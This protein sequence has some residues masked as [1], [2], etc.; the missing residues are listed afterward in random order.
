M[1][2]GSQ[3]SRAETMS[4]LTGLTHEIFVGKVV[5]NVRVE[6][7]ASQ[8]FQDAQPGDYK[9]VGKKMHF[10]LDLRKRN[11]AMATP[12]GQIPDHRGMDATKGELTP[13]R[14]YARLAMDNM[15][16]LRASGEG[17]FEDFSVRIF[18]QLWSA[19]ASMEIRHSIGSA[20]GLLCK[21]AARTSST[22]IVVKDLY[23]NAGT[24]PLNLL[25]EGDTIG[26]WDVSTAAVGGAAKVTDTGL[27][28]TTL[29][30]TVDSATTWETAVGNAIAADDLIYF[31]TTNDTTKDYFALE[32]GA[33]PNGMGDILDYAAA[34]TT[35][36]GVSETTF[37]R[38]KPFRQTSITFDHLEVTAHWLKLGAKRGFEV[39]PSTDAVLAFPSLVAQLARTLMSYQ[40]QANM[41]GTLQGGWSGL[42]IGGIDFIKDQY[43]PHN[44]LATMC[45]DQL[46][47]I[48]LGADAD[49]W[50]GDGSQWARIADFDG[51]ETYVVDYLNCFSP[52]RGAHGAL[53][54]I[55]TP[56]EVDADY[57]STPNY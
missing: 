37:P 26:W 36:F 15:V 11:G 1:A 47:R 43:L 38:W 57:D 56:D 6:S 4:V 28:Y 44:V 54:S 19:W 10:A 53:T 41:G 42:N 52:H 12:A 45:K 30:V 7:K 20:S 46:Y 39:S 16:E 9:L 18:N 49:F 29:T 23:G 24:N 5:N 3:Q 2:F 14:R 8:L 17:S 50:A 21:V 25:T 27:A 31:A 51:K 22:V 40:Q 55:V 35:V 32:R 13:V 34:A 33:A 48:P